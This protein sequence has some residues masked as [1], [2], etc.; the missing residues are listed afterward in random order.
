MW[1]LIYNK[2]SPSKYKDREKYSYDFPPPRWSPRVFID[3]EYFTNFVRPQD[4]WANESAQF[5]M[6]LWM[7]N[8]I[9]LD[10]NTNPPNTNVVSIS[11]SISQ[12]R[13]NIK[14][15]KARSLFLQ[16]Q[17]QQQQRSHVKQLAGMKRK[18]ELISDGLKAEVLERDSTITKLTV[19]KFDS[20]NGGSIDCRLMK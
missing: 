14:M 19:R 16:Q 2:K 17:M 6:P 8:M 4:R 9:A 20:S 13:R 10:G 5:K 7:M 15:W 18:Y 1:Q 12:L 11:P 3:D